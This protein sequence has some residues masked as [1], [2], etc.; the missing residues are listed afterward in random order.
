LR[1]AKTG[2]LVWK[3]PDVG[4][5][6]KPFDCFVLCRVRAYVAVMFYKRNQK[7]FYLIDVDIFLSETKGLTEERAREIGQECF[8]A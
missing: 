3:I 7:T 5:A 4:I 8:L 6:L 1:H 2:T